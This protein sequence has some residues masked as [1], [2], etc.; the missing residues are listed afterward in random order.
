MRTLTVLVIWA[1]TAAVPTG[2]VLRAP[3][4]TPEQALVDRAIEAAGGLEALKRHP[5]FVWKGEAQ[6][7][8]Q[9]KDLKIVGTWRIDP[10]DK[11][12]VETRQE[13]QAPEESRTLVI[14]G[15]QGFSLVNNVRSQLPA[16]ELENERDAFYL[17]GLMRLLPLQD[18]AVRLTALPKSEDGLDALRVTQPER[19]DVDLFFDGDARLRRLLVETLDPVTNTRRRQNVKLDGEMT[20]R[21]IRW[22]RNLTITREDGPYFELTILTLDVLPG[23]ADPRLR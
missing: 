12:I 6:V 1:L 21:G 2:Q 22:F 11:A 14:N 4:K 17:Y 8:L 16:E 20:S 5:A 7:H 10:P 18:Y 19:P 9:G 23:L 15:R 13:G 3:E